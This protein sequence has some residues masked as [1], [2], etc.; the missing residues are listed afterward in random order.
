MSADGRT[1]RSAATDEVARAA[2]HGPVVS[3]GDTH[4]QHIPLVKALEWGAGDPEDATQPATPR[5][6]AQRTRSLLVSAAIAA[7]AAAATVAVAVVVMTM[8]CAALDGDPFGWLHLRPIPEP[9][10]YPPGI[11]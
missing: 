9:M 4:D 2:E 1:Q 3:T 5:S 10:Y 6:Q 8:L 11:R 7:V